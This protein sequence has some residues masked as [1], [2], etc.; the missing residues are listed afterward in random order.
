SVVALAVADLGDAGVATR[1]LGHERCDVLEQLVNDRL[2]G[3]AARGN[4]CL[5]AAT[6]GQVSA[7]GE[8]DQALCVRTKA[9]GLGQRGGDG[10]VLEQLRGQVRE[11]QTLVSCAAAETRTLGRGRH[12]VLLVW[13]PLRPG[14]R[15]D[16]GRKGLSSI[17]G[18]PR[19]LRLL[20]HRRRHRR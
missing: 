19:S 6:R 3:A 13:W 10:F 7:L 17:A 1:A 5:D 14:P 18:G 15:W 2:V 20:P 11:H 16:T 9:L 4:D 12:S 8:G